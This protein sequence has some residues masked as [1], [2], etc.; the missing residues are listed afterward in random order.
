MS[1]TYPGTT[2]PPAAR[3]NVS[4]KMRLTTNPS[5][6]ACS[7]IG[8]RPVLEMEHDLLAEPDN[9]AD[10]HDDTAILH[11]VEHAL[12][13]LFG[14]EPAEV[15]QF[16]AVETMGHGL[17]RHQGG[18][19]TREN[20]MIGRQVVSDQLRDLAGPLQTVGAAVRQHDASNARLRAV[21]SE[22]PPDQAGGVR[23]VGG[24]GVD[25]LDPLLPGHDGVPAQDARIRARLMHSTKRRSS[26]HAQVGTHG[27][28]ERNV[29]RV[30]D[31]GET[32]EIGLGH[33][34][35]VDNVHARSSFPRHRLQDFDPLPFTGEQVLLDR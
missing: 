18:P 1:A 8:N 7:T 10:S 6:I 23:I 35:V 24:E 26:F 27:E 31:V 9:V 21:E 12:V 16:L 34:A 29:L 2:M 33:A 22:P 28:S 25:E 17:K 19:L 14:G 4:E 5:P 15:A 20:H 30:L 3:P 11:E 32:G 13:D